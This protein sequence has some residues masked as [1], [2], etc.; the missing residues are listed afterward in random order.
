V[1]AEA[2]LRDTFAAFARQ[3]ERHGIVAAV[4][5]DGA[6]GSARVRADAT[7]LAH[8]LHSLIANA[9]DA[10]PQ[11]GCVQARLATVGRGRVA[12]AIRDTGRGIAPAELAKVFRP[13]YTTKPQG[14]GLGLTLVRRAV[15]RFGGSVRID[16]E[17]GAGTTV[18]LDLP[19]A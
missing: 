12:I 2:V 4:D 15:E 7:L 3:F 17:P 13:F 6:S 1:N 19:A 14:F 9:I 11:R 16:S 5:V 10:T 8:V 18:T